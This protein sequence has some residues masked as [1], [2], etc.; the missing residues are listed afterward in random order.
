MAIYFTQIV[1]VD[2]IFVCS[3]VLLEDGCNLLFVFIQVGLRSDGLQKLGKAY[4][5]C[6]FAIEFGDEFVDGIFVGVV[7]ILIEEQNEIVRQQYAHA[8]RII[9]IEHLFQVDN[10]LNLKLARN[11]ILGLEHMQILLFKSRSI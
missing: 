10:I 5:T 7:T 1:D 3:V 6:S 11:V 2:V 8:S 4:T 9:S